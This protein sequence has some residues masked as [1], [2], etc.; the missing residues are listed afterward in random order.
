M[1]TEKSILIIDDSIMTQTLIAKHLND[2]GI[3]NIDIAVNGLVA[4][5]KIE[6]GLQEGR[7]YKLI[8][9]DW[10]MPGLDGEGVLK[11]VRGIEKMDNTYIAVLSADISSET[12]KLAKELGANIFITKPFNAAKIKTFV[13]TLNLNLSK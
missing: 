8:F 4:C 12:A 3:F 13:D 1:N 7:P 11:F 10:N 5:R 9:C 2:L 6:S